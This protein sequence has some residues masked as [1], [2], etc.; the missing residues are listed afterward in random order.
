MRGVEIK[1]CN[2]GSLCSQKKLC[3]FPFKS[4]I[5]Q[6]LIIITNRSCPLRM[7]TLNISVVLRCFAEGPGKKYSVGV[8]VS[9]A[10]N[11]NW[12]SGIEDNSD[13]GAEIQQA[14]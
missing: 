8:I 10:M 13:C 12:R 9:I 7:A 5:N 6:Q 4:V 3:D 1:L 11:L 2:V 14:R